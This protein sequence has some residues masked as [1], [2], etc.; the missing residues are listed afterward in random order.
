MGTR[1]EVFWTGITPTVGMDNRVQA[2]SFYGNSVTQILQL[3]TIT[4]SIKQALEVMAVRYD[5]MPY[6]GSGHHEHINIYHGT[7]DPYDEGDKE[8]ICHINV[9]SLIITLVIK[10]RVHLLRESAHTNWDIYG[11][12]LVYSGQLNTGEHAYGTHPDLLCKKRL[13]AE[14]TSSEDSQPRN[15]LPLQTGNIRPKRGI[16]KYVRI[17]TPSNPPGGVLM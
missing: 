1:F 7:Q 12:L 14:G 6:Q 10:D 4:I 8:G 3:D 11:A 16:R 17:F 5:T 2:H 9:G 15:D 13:L